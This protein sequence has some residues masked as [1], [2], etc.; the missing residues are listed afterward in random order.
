MR[1]IRN[2]ML[3]LGILL[4]SISSVW[5]DTTAEKQ[6]LES[7][8]STRGTDYISVLESA[9]ANQALRDSVNTLYRNSFAVIDTVDG[10]FVFQGFFTLD[11]VKPAIAKVDTLYFAPEVADYF[12]DS[13]MTV[14]QATF[15]RI[16]PMWRDEL[17]KCSGKNAPARQT[18][19][20]RIRRQWPNPLDSLPY[21]KEGIDYALCGG[22]NCYMQRLLADTTT[23]KYSSDPENRALCILNSDVNFKVLAWMIEAFRLSNIYNQ[24]KQQPLIYDV[25]LQKARRLAELNKTQPMEFIVRTEDT[26][27]TGSIHMAKVTMIAP[28]HPKSI[29]YSLDGGVTWAL[30]DSIARTDAGADTI[31]FRLLDYSYFDTIT[32]PVIL[33]VRPRGLTLTS[34]DAEKV[35]DGTPLTNSDV[36]ESGDGFVMGESAGYSFTGSQTEVGSSANTFSYTLAEDT[37]AQNYQISTVNGTLRIRPRSVTPIAITIDNHEKMYDGTPLNATYTYSGALQ[38]GDYL[39]VTLDTDE[40]TDAGMDSVRVSSLAIYDADGMDMTEGYNV[41]NPIS[42]S[43]KVTPREVVL[44]SGDAEKAFDGTALTNTEVVVSGDGFAAG[45]G[46]SYDVTGSQ[47]KVGESAN[48]F[49]YTLNEGTKADNYT[50]STVEGTLTV[51]CNIEPQIVGMYD[52]WNIVLDVKALTD[53]LAAYGVATE[54]QPENVTWYANDEPASPATGFFH[55]E[56]KHMEAVYYAI[57]YVPEAKE[58]MGIDHF[59]SNTLY[60]VAPTAPARNTTEKRIENNQLIIIRDGKMFNA[61]GIAL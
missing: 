5:A 57:V 26:L 4:S 22:I 8:F 12:G 28:L 48:A 7:Y 20:S 35:Y 41:A 31:L 25:P 21:R 43:L 32:A 38:Q 56:D 10:E 13:V 54:L 51:Y 18:A 3:C 24:A 15:R 37:K 60:W 33:H 14:M 34:G 30:G 46:A 36:R 52:Q 2:I 55:T 50:I 44:T 27:Y 23:S 45:E 29:E 9:A 58:V 61:Q 19:I 39:N 40:R 47:T 16:L 42:G 17:M 6:Y 49:S 59:R 11:G 1:K 53:T